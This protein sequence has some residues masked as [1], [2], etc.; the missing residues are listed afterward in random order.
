MSSRQ[1]EEK[2][3]CR[4]RH[5]VSDLD[6]VNWF[7]LFHPLP[8]SAWADVKLAE[9]AEQV[10]KIVEYHESKSTQPRF[11]TWW[12]TLLMHMPRWAVLHMHMSMLRSC[13]DMLFNLT[14]PYW[15]MPHAS[16][17][18]YG[19]LDFLSTSHSTTYKSSASWRHIT[20]L[21]SEST[22]GPFIR[23]LVWLA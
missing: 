17:T 5:H 21:V 4:V 3:F 14:I 6:W 22:S 12:R 10:G 19:F 23:S 2:H 20:C 16:A 9:L 11:E 18:F 7:W 15:V 8:G 13:Q 1:V